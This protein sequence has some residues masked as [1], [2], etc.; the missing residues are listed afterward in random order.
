MNPSNN[1]PPILNTSRLHDHEVEQLACL[2]SNHLLGLTRL[3]LAYCQTA[4]F[5]T[6]MAASQLCIPALFAAG[7]LSCRTV[8]DELDDRVCATHFAYTWNPLRR[9]LQLIEVPNEG[10]IR[11]FELGKPRDVAFLETHCWVELPFD[12]RILDISTGGLV[13]ESRLTGLKEWKSPSPPRYYCGLRQLSQNVYFEAVTEATRVALRVGYS[14]LCLS[15]PSA[16]QSVIRQQMQTE[17][18]LASSFL[19]TGG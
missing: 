4:A 15:N 19:G 1:H 6:M 12:G 8:H 10:F 17:A 7:R 11:A 13:S 16:A 5:A 9:C 18:L 3:S 2:A 14:C